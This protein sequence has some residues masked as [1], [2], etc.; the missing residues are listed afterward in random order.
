MQM[1]LEGFRKKVWALEL[2]IEQAKAN[3]AKRE[4]IQEEQAEALSAYQALV[5]LYEEM[6]RLSSYII[7]ETNKYRRRSIEILEQ[8][9]TNNLALVFP[10]EEYVAKFDYK[11]HGDEPTAQLLIGVRNEK[12]EYEYTSPS[13]LLGGLAQQLTAF[14]CIFSVLSIMGVK[15][16]FMDEPFNGGDGKSLTEMRPL[17]QAIY[18][19]GIQMVGIEHKGQLFEGIP[20]KMIELMKDRYKGKIIV[21]STVDSEDE[22]LNIA[23]SLARMGSEI[24]KKKMNLDAEADDVLASVE[25]QL[26][27]A[28][29]EGII[30]GMFMSEEISPATSPIITAAVNEHVKEEITSEAEDAGSLQSSPVR[31]HRND[32]LKSA[33]LSNWEAGG[34]R[35]TEPA[36]LAPAAVQVQENRTE[37]SEFADMM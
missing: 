12:G 21:R 2:E 7:I 3:N 11:P 10:E 8:E 14:S 17:F 37:A 18:E 16:I 32:W 31:S 25:S 35:V 33:P 22:T 15:T 9:I 29:L 19:L 1:T 28:G 30:S 27:S 20:H 6:K 23:N 24:M 36:E 13:L 5:S 4:K 26:S 34:G